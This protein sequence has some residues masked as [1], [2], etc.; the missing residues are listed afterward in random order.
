MASPDGSK[1]KVRS[2]KLQKNKEA[3]CQKLKGSE[4]QKSRDS[5]A[6]IRRAER[7]ELGKRDELKF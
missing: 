6:H 7:D 2:R 3:E 4:V 1:K 5:K